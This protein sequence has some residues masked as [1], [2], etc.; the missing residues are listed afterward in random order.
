MPPPNPTDA[1]A[2]GKIVFVGNIPYGLTEEQITEIFGSAGRVLSFR[3]VYDRETGRPKG[4]GFAEYSDAE[5]AASAVRN[6]D[7]YEIMGRKLRVD[8]SHEGAAPE[9]Y[10][11]TPPAPVVSSTPALPAG[12]DIPGGIT[13][14]DAISTTLKQLPAPQLLEILGQMKTLVSQ[15]PVKATELL[16]QAPQLSY[17]IFQALL[18]MNLVDTSV[19]TQ[20]IEG[21]AATAPPPVPT[22]QQQP[23]QQYY[24][25]PTPAPPVAPVPMAQDRHQLLQS[26]MHLT[27]EQIAAF[28]PEQQQQIM[29]LKQSLLA[30]GGAL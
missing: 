5:T 8:F 29:Y 2:A 30:Q 25:T 27:P 23:Q 15:D 6:L 19:L 11:P 10:V 9:D 1:R 3:L 7:N 17:A 12:V 16:R 21:S 22:P 26:V 24:A 13:A 18:L 20:V 14:P 28:P 4:F